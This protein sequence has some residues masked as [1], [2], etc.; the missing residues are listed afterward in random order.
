MDSADGATVHA[1]E[2]MPLKSNADQMA[3]SEGT[4]E[5]LERAA[6]METRQIDS[7]TSSSSLGAHAPHPGDVPMKEFRS[8]RPASARG[9]AVR[10]AD[11]QE[12]QVSRERDIGAAGYHQ[13]RPLSSPAHMRRKGGEGNVSVVDRFVF[14]LPYVWLQVFIVH[15]CAFM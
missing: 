12:H 14:F 8:S 2:A 6:D 5:Q 15:F 3:T 1:H 7:S 13:R 11:I 9:G 10:T 4:Q